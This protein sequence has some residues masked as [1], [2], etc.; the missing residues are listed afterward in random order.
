[1][2]VFD[3][4]LAVNSWEHKGEIEHFVLAVATFTAA[5][6]RRYVKLHLPIR[7]ILRPDPP[8]NCQLNVRKLPKT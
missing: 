2:S 7:P 5:H 6:R 4:S 8:E 1:M 3:V